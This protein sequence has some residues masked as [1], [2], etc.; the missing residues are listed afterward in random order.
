MHTEFI[1]SDMMD[2]VDDALRAVDSIGEDIQNYPACEYLLQSMFL[3]LT[4]Y[5]E[6]KLKCILWHVASWDFD[7][8]RKVLGGSERDYSIGEA[9]KLE[10]KNK[11]WKALTTSMGNKESPYKAPDSAAIQAQIDAVGNALKDRLSRSA[12]T[13]WLPRDYTDFE[14]FLKNT[15]AFEEGYLTSPNKFF[16]G[17][18]NL[19]EAYELVYKHRNRCAHNLRSY[20]Y[21][22]NNLDEMLK[23]KK[24]ADNYFTMIFVLLLIDNAFVEAYHQ[25]HK[26]V[27]LRPAYTRP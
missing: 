24:G 26:K 27:L 25:Y 9:S 3:K 5:Q 18:S 14:K 1:M 11:V 21:D 4:G 15:K 6:Q 12:L 13:K 22:T 20:Q 7:V 16:G 8:R 17:D 2:I 10:D 19:K 23:D